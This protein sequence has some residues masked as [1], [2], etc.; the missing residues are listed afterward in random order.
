MLPLIVS[1]TLVTVTVVLGYSYTNEAQGS[2][3]VVRGLFSGRFMKSLMHADLYT[4]TAYMANVDLRIAS[5][6]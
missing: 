4:H 1:T 3:T 2:R 5:I 6:A